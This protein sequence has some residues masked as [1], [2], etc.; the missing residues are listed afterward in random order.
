MADPTLLV[1]P[2]GLETKISNTDNNNDDEL[3][4]PHTLTALLILLAWLFYA[5]IRTNHEDTENSVKLGILAAIC[6]FVFIGML[7][8]RNGPFVRPSIPFWRAILSLS[9][10]YQLFLVFM[11][12]LNKKDARQFMTYFDPAL[13]IELPERSYADNCE[14]SY[15]NIMAQID[16]FVVAHAVGWYGKA[17]IIRDYWLCWILSV[18]FELLEY[19]LEH[20]L[21][22][23]AECWW[24]HWILDVLLCNWA[25]IYFGMKTCQYLE[26]KEYSW[27][28]LRQIKSLRG[29][30]KRAVQQFTPKGWTRF[31][32]KTTSSPKNY[33]GTL[34]LML[35]FLQCEL[36]CFYLKALLWVP[37]EHPLNTYRLTL[38]FLFAL[39][40]A[41]DMY[42]YIS[43]SNTERLG[44]HAWLFICNIMTESLIC[45]K[46][47]ENEFTVPAP[48][49]VK[50]AW[51]IILSFLLVIFPF[52]RFVIYPK[53]S[54]AIEG[55]DE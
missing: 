46:F 21:N 53:K 37:P 50:I 36:N 16:I 47:S 43:D 18:T 14:T 38:V 42:Q 40:G 22:N 35:V 45:L 31:E 23:F 33:F 49:F 54:S 20:Q 11:L 3:F 55:K 17:M 1:K 6:C 15:S 8:L 7:Q 25:G 30:A 51:S 41:R 48:M 2:S 10:L 12:F 26:V 27:V 44:V 28:G 4:H 13:G 52:W 24:D 9:V 29:K 32:W 19:S 5:G 34:G 39:P